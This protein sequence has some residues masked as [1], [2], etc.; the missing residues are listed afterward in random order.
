[1]FCKN[2][3]NPL[4]DNARFCPVCGTEQTPMQEAP[5]Q[6]APVQA[7][8]EPVQY[9]PQQT[10]AMPAQEE[11]PA[12]YQA[13]VQQAPVQNQEPANQNPPL[14]QPAIDKVKNF[15]FDKINPAKNPLPAIITGGVIVVIVALIVVTNLIFSGGVSGLF[16]KFED[17]INDGD[18]KA[19]MELVPD[20]VA[21]EDGADMLS[22]SLSYIG[23]LGVE[24]DMEVLNETDVTYQDSEYD[25]S[26]TWQQ[27]IQNRYSDYKGYKGEQ[28]DKVEKVKVKMELDGA[29]GQLASSLAGS[30]NTVQEFTVVKLDGDWYIYG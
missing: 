2:C 1:M 20:F 22:S 18:S 19:I 27:Y 26:Y 5:V 10:V 13:P 3:G 16:N 7:P 28:V 6:Q 9:Q 8:A 17:A 24:I 21:T 30:D 4:D 12:Q 15:S 25:S 23:T 14:F 11:A 29:L